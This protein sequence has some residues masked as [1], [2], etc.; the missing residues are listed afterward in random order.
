MG[1][2]SYSNNLS[3]NLS[4][5]FTSTGTCIPDQAERLTSPPRVEGVPVGLHD[6]VDLGH[7]LALQALSVHRVPQR[8]L[9]VFYTA[10]SLTF[11]SVVNSTRSSANKLCTLVFYGIIQIL[12]LKIELPCSGFRT[13]KMKTLENIFHFF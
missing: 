2:P 8:Y 12:Q 1:L 5:Q 11:S 13:Q 10:P 4:D 6:G 9:T 3:T 7:P